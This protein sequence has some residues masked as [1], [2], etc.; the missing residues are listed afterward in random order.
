MRPTARSANCALKT[1]SCGG[2]CWNASP[3]ASPCVYCWL[4]SITRIACEGLPKPFTLSITRDTPWPTA[5]TPMFIP[6]STYQNPCESH[7]IPLSPTLCYTLLTCS[8]LLLPMKSK[9]SSVHPNVQVYR[10]NPIE[11]F[12]T[13]SSRSHSKSRDLRSKF[14]CLFV[15]LF[16]FILNWFIQLS[17]SERSGEPSSSLFCFLFFIII[18]FGAMEQTRHAKLRIY[19]GVIHFSMITIPIHANELIILIK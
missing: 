17:S 3:A 5:T 9:L 7:G 19:Y 4:S 10:F 1:Y 2:S 6:T 8:N 18:C 14:V 16:F 15:C 13:N 11:L 12:R